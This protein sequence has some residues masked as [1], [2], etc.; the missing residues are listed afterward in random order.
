MSRQ[1]KIAAF[2][3]FLLAKNREL[4]EAIRSRRGD[5]TKQSILQELTTS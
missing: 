4:S 5:K 1:E 3:T 2:D